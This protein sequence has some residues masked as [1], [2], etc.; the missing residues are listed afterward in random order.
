[1]RW[2]T[3]AFERLSLYEK[4]WSTPISRLAKGFGLSDV[5]LRK[6]CKRLAIPLPGLGYWAKLQ[7]GRSLPTPPLPRF[8]GETTYVHRRRI[9]DEAITRQQKVDAALSATEALP[10]PSV[11][12][13]KDPSEFHALVRRTARAMRKPRAGDRGLQCSRPPGVFRIDVS[14]ESASRALRILDGLW[15]ALEAVGAK[16]SRS[17]ENFEWLRID[18]DGERLGLHIHETVRRHDRPL[19]SEEKRKLEENR[20]TYIADRYSWEPTGRLNLTILSS[21][22][23]VLQRVH[24]GQE[25]LENKLGEVI[26]AYRRAAVEQLIAREEAE[27]AARR[28]EEAERIRKERAQIADKQL[29]RLRT[30]ETLAKQLERAQQLRHLADALER[31]GVVLVS[32]DDDVEKEQS[33]GQLGQVAWL[34]RAADWLD[35]TIRKHWPEVDGGDSP[36]WWWEYQREMGAQP[37]RY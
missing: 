18:V 28:F 23:S 22:D 24:D 21:T 32:E 33:K 35:P 31:A 29:H 3:I 17:G 8:N 19:T 25:K 30:F 2:E 36:Y 37:K 6:I 7:H 27:A 5:G 20:L 9:D 16:P 4:A 26:T 10:E 15:I 12:L 14:P 1:M 11:V 34:R 13:K